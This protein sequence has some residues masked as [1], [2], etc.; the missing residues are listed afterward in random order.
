MIK[1][2]LIITLVLLLLIVQ[3]L[4]IYRRCFR[5]LCYTFVSHV[6]NHSSNYIIMNVTSKMKMLGSNY[7]VAYNLCCKVVFTYL[8][9]WNL[10]SFRYACL[11]NAGLK[12][13]GYEII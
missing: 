6:C 2:P 3:A 12:V 4:S 7:V 11:V 10:T 9:H 8:R 13:V 1:K 5:V